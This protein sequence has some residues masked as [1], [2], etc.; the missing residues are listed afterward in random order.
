MGNARGGVGVGAR[1]GDGL[2]QCTFKKHK[3][4]LR[5]YELARPT[6]RQQ[7]QLL[8]VNLFL[9]ESRDKLDEPN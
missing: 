4:V 2:A 7:K 1:V 5:F 3:I 6:L 8:A 9:E